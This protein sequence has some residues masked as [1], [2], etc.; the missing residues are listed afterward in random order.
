MPI[1]QGI[2]PVEHSELTYKTPAG[3]LL[4]LMI[5][6]TRSAVVPT[7]CRPKSTLLTFAAAICAAAGPGS[8]AASASIASRIGYRAPLGERLSLGLRP[9]L[10]SQAKHS[11]MP[12]R[13]SP[14]LKCEVFRKPK[15]LRCHADCRAEQ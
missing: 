13:Y 1:K 3:S 12:M 5:S 6:M 14:F 7:G 4:A 11:R 2:G 8:P 9:L 10:P 15:I